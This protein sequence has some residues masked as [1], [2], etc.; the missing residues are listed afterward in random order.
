MPDIQKLLDIMSALRR[1]CP[2]DRSQSF[3]TIAPYTLEEAYEVA[4]AI[5]NRDWPGLQDELGDLL[6]QVVFHSEL[7]EEAGHFQFDDVVAAICNK[8]E[9]RHPHVFGT[10]EERAEGPKADSWEAIKAAERALQDAN[11]ALDGI[12]LAQPAL[13]RAAKLG[14]RASRVGFDWPDTTGVLEKID[15]ERAELVAACATGGQAER[16]HELGDLLFSVVNLS[17]HLQIDPERA[18]AG[19]NRRFEARFRHLEAS[20][21]ER[22][23]TPADCNTDALE[24]AWVDAKEALERKS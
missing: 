5:A 10:A 22:G 24:A 12:A 6:F 11:S 3:E 14:Q 8:L 17:R 15:E 19:A 23:T 20:L 7:A 16:E 13:S 21:R 2:W 18:L 9:R 4:D 1:D